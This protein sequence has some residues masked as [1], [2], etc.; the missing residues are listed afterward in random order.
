MAAVPGQAVADQF[1]AAVEAHEPSGG[2]QWYVDKRVID[3][4]ADEFWAVIAA[5]AVQQPI[6]ELSE[7]QQF[8]V[9]EARNILA[10]WDLAM[11]IGVSRE[12]VLADQV[13]HLL[14]II[15]QMDPQ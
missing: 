7:S 11:P 3:C 15:D 5:V 1:R 6:A 2:S 10:T 13:R 4:D 14:A 12:T 8:Q 9:S